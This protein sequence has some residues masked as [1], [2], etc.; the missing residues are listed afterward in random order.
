M[1]SFGRDLRLLSEQLNASDGDV[2]NLI[3]A[4]PPVSVR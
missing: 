2:R 1:E 3:A 4:G